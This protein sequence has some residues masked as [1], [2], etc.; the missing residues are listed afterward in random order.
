M[1][2]LAKQIIIAIIFFLILAGF[3][4][5]VYWNILPNPSCFDNIQNQNEEGIDCGGPC[6]SCEAAALKNLEIIWVKSLYVKDNFY[7]LAA[8]IKNPNQNYGSGRIVYYFKF[9]DLDDNLIGQE[10][11]TAYILPNQLKYLI[12]PKIESRKTIKKIEILFEPI[13]WQKLKEYQAPQLAVSQ[14]EYSLSESGQPAKSQVSGLVI[15][16]TA[17]DFDQ[18]DIDV[19]LFNQAGE[20]I[21]LNTTRVNTLLAGQERSFIVAWFEPIKE[22]VVSIEAEPE[23]NLFDSDNYMKRYGTLEKFKEY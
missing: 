1:T 20:I 13:E 18:I 5:L 19:L 4:F 11:G 23:T 3:G 6:Q 16:K 7:D 2:R 14:K 10:K 12:A 21:G 8:R 17:F 9:Y 22:P 15:N